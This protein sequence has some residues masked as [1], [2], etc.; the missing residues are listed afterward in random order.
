MG[1]LAYPTDFM[2]MHDLIK[3]DVCFVLLKWLV[4]EAQ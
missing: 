1:Q 4:K 3:K 2:T